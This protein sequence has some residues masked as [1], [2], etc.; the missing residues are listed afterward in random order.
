METGIQIKSITKPIR[1][2]TPILPRTTRH[3]I[4]PTDGTV[5]QTS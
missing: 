1:Y 3:A 4:F 2:H 5:L